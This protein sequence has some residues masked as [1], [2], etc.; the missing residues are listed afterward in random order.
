MS[1]SPGDVS[2]AV[3]HARAIHSQIRRAQ[4]MDSAELYSYAKE[5]QVPIEL[6][7]RTAELGRLPV[8]NFA[9]GGLGKQYLFLDMSRLL[10]C[11]LSTS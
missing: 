3:R 5:L 8:V 9:A 6:L 10:Y 1:Y 7:K 4:S 2:Q 11:Y